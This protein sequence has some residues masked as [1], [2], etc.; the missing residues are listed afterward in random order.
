M[1][2]RQI[3]KLTS[4]LLGKAWSAARTEQPG[5]KVIFCLHSVNP[6]ARHSTIH[7]DAFDRILGW[8]RSHTDLMDLETL[9]EADRSGNARPAVALTFDDGHKDNLTHAMPIAQKHGVS[10]TVYIPTGV[11]ERDS[12]ALLRFR[13]TLRQKTADF[14]V[15]SWDDAAS[16]I[17]GGFSIGS[18]TW[19]HP[20]LS[21]L[22]DE[23][24]RFQLESSRNLIRKRLGLSQFGMA[25]PYGKLGRNVDRRVVSLTESAGYSYGLCV[26]HRALSPNDSRFQLPRFILNSGDLESLRRKVTGE[27]DFHGFISRH[28]PEWSARLLSPA[29][30]HE[31]EGALPPLCAPENPSK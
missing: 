13:S 15:L 5:R 31:D 6:S 16:L 7:P 4:G 19:D 12:R 2:A 22:P 26:E 11:I 24:I 10:F 3:K 30:F 29:D 20:M 27:E 25:Y 14:E 8:L 23:G 18:H 28:M 1:N 21:H 17:E 9:L